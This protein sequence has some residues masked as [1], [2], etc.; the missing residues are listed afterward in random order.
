VAGVAVDSRDRVYLFCRDEH[1][2]MVYDR[3]GRFLQAWGAGLFPRAHGITVGPDDAVYCTDQRDHT[4][5]KFTPEGELLLTLGTSGVPS[6][7]G[8]DGHDLR[9]VTRPGPPFNNPANLAVAPNGELYVA[10]GYGNSRVHRFSPDGELL[11][12]WGEPGTGPSQFMLPHGIRVH[13][14]GRVFVCDMENDRVQIFGPRGE[15]LEAWEGLQRPSQLAFDGEGRVYISHH[16]WRGGEFRYRSGGRVEAPVPGHISVL[17]DRG[18]L[19]A[20]WG[21]PD[22]CAPGNVM[23]AHGLAVDSRGDLYVAE[24]TWSF[25]VSKGLAPPDCHTFQKFTR[26]AD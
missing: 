8:Y 17:D 9:T 19:L 26:S 5:R 1:P 16:W 24:V 6:A 3:A 7:T 12:S 21:G 18:T 10:D 25:A 4:V 20:R 22:G 14:D 15:Y 2:V 11:Q 13:R 23:A